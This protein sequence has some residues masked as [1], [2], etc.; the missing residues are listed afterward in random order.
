MIRSFKPEPTRLEDVYYALLEALMPEGAIPYQQILVALTQYQHVN[1][2][3]LIER[4][5]ALGI[6][7]IARHQRLRRGDLTHEDFT[8]GNSRVTSI[9]QPLFHVLPD[10]YR[11]TADVDSLSV[12]EAFTLR[13]NYAPAPTAGLPVLATVAVPYFQA[14]S[15]AARPVTLPQLHYLLVH[16]NDRLRALAS[17][18]AAA[19]QMPRCYELYRTV[20]D[21]V[22]FDVVHEP[23]AALGG[24]D[25]GLGVLE[26][27]L[28]QFYRWE[29]VWSALL[30]DPNL[31]D[32]LLLLFTHACGRRLTAVVY[33]PAACPTY[34]AALQDY[35]QYFQ[36]V[37]YG[38][39]FR[40]VPWSQRRQ[41]IPV[42]YDPHTYLR[43]DLRGHFTP[44]PY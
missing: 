29:D 28:S 20:Q 23:G 14:G 16:G 26:F 11:Q 35:G 8:F 25:S 31:D 6:L 27:E 5:V 42:H 15:P 12:D 33:L 38:H 18:M 4:A 7:T 30:G 34:T 44:R 9:A 43:S 41:R 32:A 24:A 36:T 10:S 2:P 17:S 1:P 22:V 40:L 19:S 13:E 39:L 21:A 3:R 37:G